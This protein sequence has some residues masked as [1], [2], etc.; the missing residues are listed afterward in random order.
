MKKILLITLI[1]S[2]FAATSAFA[3]CGTCGVGEDGKEACKA[4]CVKKCCAKKAKDC[5]ADCEKPCCNKEKAEEATADETAVAPKKSGAC[6]AAK[7]G[8]PA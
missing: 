5:A 2:L 1:G 3:N 4:E 8:S 7:A 6:C